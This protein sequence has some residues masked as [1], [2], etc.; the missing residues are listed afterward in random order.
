MDVVLGVIIFISVDKPDDDKVGCWLG[1]ILGTQCS[2]TV[3]VMCLPFVL[4]QWDKQMKYSLNLQLF[5]E[6]TVL[7]C[8]MIFTVFLV[9][10]TSLSTFNFC[11]RSLLDICWR[12]FLKFW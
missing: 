3:F 11:V 12:S 2:R 5:V 8:E 7:L 4:A 9:A 10:K 6:A 1:R